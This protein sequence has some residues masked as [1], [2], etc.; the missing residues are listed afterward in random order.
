MAASSAPCIESNSLLLLQAEAEPELVQALPERHHRGRQVALV[1]AGLCGA[2]GLLGVAALH[3]AR[4][5]QHAAVSS[6]GSGAIMQAESL[7]A[8]TARQSLRNAT[9]SAEDEDACA[10]TGMGCLKSKCCKDPG[11]Q[12]HTKNA[13]WAQCMAECVPGPNVRDQVSNSAWECK[14]LGERTAGEPKQC[15]DDGE[16]CS[17]TKCCNSGGTQCFEKNEFWATCKPQCTPGPDL[18]A[19]D[20][21][22]WSCKR[23]GPRTMGAAP[24][25]ETKCANTGEN[26]EMKG[27]CQDEGHQC[28]KKG[29]GWSQ[30]RP[31]CKKGEKLQAWDTPWDCTPFGPRT[32][33]FEKSEQPASGQV[34]KWVEEKCSEE[35]ENCLDSKC[36]HGVGEQCY[37]KS[38]FWG[39]CKPSCDTAPDPND[40]NKS[41]SCETVGPKSWGLAIKGW[42]SL[43]CFSLYMPS[44][45][46]GPLLK[47]VLKANAGIF[48]CD[49]YDV[50]AAEPDTLGT[51]EDG[52]EVK[53]IQIPKI[54]VGVSQDGT[55]GNAKLFMAVWDKVIAGGRFRNYDWT[56]KVDPDAVLVPWRIRDHMRSHV[57]QKVYVVNCNKFPGSPNFPMMYGAVEVF[58]QSAMVQYAQ[59]SWKCGKQLPWASW[60]EDYY[61]T[62]CM[63]FIGVGRIGDFGILGDNMCTGANC[64]DG[65]I[66]SFHPFKSEGLWMQCWGKATAPPPKPGAAV[67]AR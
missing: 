43:Y 34:A 58:S 55:A 26:C 29:P 48:H 12:C 59:N 13:F 19:E 35:G 27:C 41:W 24:W 16:D 3:N 47:S 57:G 21:K 45:Y 60:G 49:G 37:R 11:M 46:E 33:A 9:R 65:G 39:S 44:G 38:E 56:I 28:Y 18:T 52:I 10:A 64:A 50:F 1:A 63:D 5:A 62:H 17:S 7:V 40:G 32:P 42:P 36:C 66:A 23:L 14:K 20:S 67:P 2:V 22:P 30:C 54:S 6:T 15:S 51:S 8:R 4:S 53:A 25:V 31:S 61:M